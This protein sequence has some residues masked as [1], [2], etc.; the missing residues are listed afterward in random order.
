MDGSDEDPSSFRQAPREPKL[1]IIDASFHHQPL[2]LDY[3]DTHP[4]TLQAW[5]SSHPL[6]SGRS[7]RA[8]TDSEE[9]EN[10]REVLRQRRL[11]RHSALINHVSPGDTYSGIKAIKLA[12][13]EHELPIKMAYKQLD[14][15]AAN[16]E[17][18][19]A[20]IEKNRSLL[21]L[22]VKRNNSRYTRAAFTGWRLYVDRK[23]GQ[24]A[25]LKHAEILI[26]QGL[27]SRT[28]K[29]WCLY[30]LWNRKYKRFLSSVQKILHRHL[31]QRIWKSWVA[32][33]RQRVKKDEDRRKEKRLLKDMNIKIKERLERR[34]EIIMHRKRLEKLFNA[35][36]EGCQLVRLK[37]CYLK[38]LYQIMSKKKIGR[39]F[40]TWNHL[41]KVH[42]F[43]MRAVKRFANRRLGAC[44]RAWR[45]KNF[46]VEICSRKLQRKRLALI[47]AVWTSTTGSNKDLKS[48]IQRKR[49]M[50]YFY[51][52]R[53]GCQE[54][55]WSRC[56]QEKLARKLLNCK[57]KLAFQGWLHFMQIHEQK[58]MLKLQD[59]VAIIEKENERSKQ[60]CARL[61]RIVESGEWGRQQFAEIL[62]AKDVLSVEREALTALIG[63]LNQQQT[64]VLEQ[65]EKND[66][67]MRHFKDQLFGN[68]FINHN[69]LLI[70]GA[71]SFNTVV[72]ALKMDALKRGVHPEFLCA[73]DRLAMD[74]V[75]VFP[76]GE[77]RLCTR[78]I[79]ILMSIAFDEGGYLKDLAH[80]REPLLQN[81]HDM[82][83]DAS[84]QWSS[85]MSLT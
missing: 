55:S 63:R 21:L 58:R 33:V 20:S 52:F 68:N 73:V 35:L 61:S 69:K 7:S 6:V 1:A 15:L 19:R 8:S 70:K 60:E 38:D 40:N 14:E 11:G 84:K 54:A 53:Q 71:S 77:I 65:K 72:R 49:L 32:F 29:S 36:I 43:Y 9:L 82:Q 16:A 56:L 41:R 80:S 74:K 59:Y 85:I 17:R 26:L 45:N 34:A 51:A 12:I 10:V 76:D 5:H 3:S 23:T 31:L 83:F 81:L 39:I 27:L 64:A 4:S 67:E 44:F 50:W 30:V 22:Q 47:F 18:V 28:F 25:K 46:Y 57:L 42:S 75:S 62:E 66:H 24:K 79:C 2:G 78:A 48:K 37:R 13:Q